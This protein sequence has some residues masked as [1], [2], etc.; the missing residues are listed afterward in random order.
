QHERDM[1]RYA[2]CYAPDF[3]GVRRT[4]GGKVLNLDRAAWLKDRA[5]ISSQPIEIETAEVD[6]TADE[7]DGTAVITL[8]QRFRR[9][10]YAEHGHK[11][12]IARRAG[13]AMQFTSEEMLDSQRGWDEDEYASQIPLQAA[14]CRVA[15]DPS[16]HKYLVT[17][18][19]DEDYAEVLRVAAKARKAKRPAEIVWGPAFVGL[20]PGFWAL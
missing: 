2:G 7:E 5:R 8:V 13:A 10:D 18:A 12:F 1:E 4:P 16:N 17:L 14:D 19:R 15:F 20:G 3:K 11:R 6:V 9:G